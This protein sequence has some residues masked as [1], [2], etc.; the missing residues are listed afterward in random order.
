MRV[1][2]ALKPPP[3]PATGLEKT[4][5]QQQ[6]QQEIEMLWRKMPCSNIRCCHN[7]R[8]ICIHTEKQVTYLSSITAATS[9]LSLLLPH[10]NRT[11]QT[12]P[13]AS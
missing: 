10:P 12:V 4:T 6:Q 1:R 11:C 8:P 7:L 2:G 5:R 13:D 3:P 9:F